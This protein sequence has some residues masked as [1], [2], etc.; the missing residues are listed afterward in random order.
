LTVKSIIRKAGILAAVLVVCAGAK[1]RA[2]TIDVKVPFPFMVQGKTL[3]A[4]EY[5]LENDGAVVMIRSTK[6]NS[7]GLFVMTRPADGRDPAGDRPS[8][9]FTRHET[10][11]R[12]TDIW[13]SDSQG[14]AIG[15]H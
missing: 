9:I 4:G 11:Y 13:E 8:L 12:L 1:A 5:R 6:G 3:P 7:A 2:A 15:G 14:L 10:Q